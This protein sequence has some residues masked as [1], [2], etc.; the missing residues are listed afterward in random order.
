M[1]NSF[2][3]VLCL[4]QHTSCL[5]DSRFNLGCSCKAYLQSG[6]MISVVLLPFCAGTMTKSSK[7][8]PD[9]SLNAPFFCNIFPHTYV[10]FVP[11][12]QGEN[13]CSSY[14]TLDQHI[15]R[16]CLH[17]WDVGWVRRQQQQSCVSLV[18]WLGRGQH[19]PGLAQSR[20]A[21]MPATK[22]TC[23]DA[24]PKRAAPA[25]TLHSP[26][27]DPDCWGERAGW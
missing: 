26:C 22:N 17:K 2:T 10:S 12:G 6:C 24:P 3:T 7:C 11:G 21:A 23:S 8:P 25:A 13:E 1:V 20:I 9:N 14:W 18:L 5:T 16:R 27:L 4:R 19:G 15:A